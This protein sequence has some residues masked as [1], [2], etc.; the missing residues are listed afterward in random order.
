MSVSKGLGVQFES[1]ILKMCDWHV[2][3]LD[4]LLVFSLFFFLYFMVFFFFLVNF[5][6]GQIIGGAG[7]LLTM[8]SIHRC[9]FHSHKIWATRIKENNE[10]EP[11]FLKKWIN[12]NLNLHFGSPNHELSYFFWSGPIGFPSKLM[13][14]KLNHDLICLHPGALSEDLETNL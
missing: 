12:L 6:I 8:S 9:I 4:I 7:V 11:I 14:C 5:R 1:P 10:K 3:G 13:A 2:K